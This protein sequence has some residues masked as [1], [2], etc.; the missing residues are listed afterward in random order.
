MFPKDSIFLL[1]KKLKNKKIA[2]TGSNGFIASHVV[3]IINEY[4]LT[5]KKI[6]IR[7]L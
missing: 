5:N 1:K 2:V 4:N 7:F 3:K 6:E